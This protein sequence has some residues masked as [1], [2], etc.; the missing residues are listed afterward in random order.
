MLRVV[1]NNPLCQYMSI[2]G[3]NIFFPQNFLPSEKLHHE[4]AVPYQL[5][6]VPTVQGLFFS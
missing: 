6:V 5:T 1:F 4:L 3:K 2:V